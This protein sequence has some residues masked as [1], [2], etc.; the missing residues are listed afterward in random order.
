MI[1]TQ[2]SSMLDPELLSVFCRVAETLNFS[3][4]ATYLGVAQPVVTRKI[5]RLEEILGVPLFLRS[6]RGCKLTPEGELLATKA[7]GILLQLA[8]LK[9]E[10]GHSNIG[11]SGSIA[12]GMTGAAG[13]LLAPHLMP[14]IAT[15]W[16]N[17]RVELYE[18]VTRHLL[19]S[20]VNRELSLALVYDPPPDLGLLTQPLLMDHLYLAGPADATEE[21]KAI[22]KA[23]VK[24]IARLP[25]VLPVRSQIIREL[26]EDA[27]AEESLPLKPRYEANSPIML[28]AMVTQGLGYTVLTMSSLEQDL[29][30]GKLAAIPILDRGMSLTLSLVTNTDYGQ[31]RVVHMM[32]GLISDIVQNLVKSNQWPGSPQLMQVRPFS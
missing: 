23:S 18:A 14:A 6:N 13:T 1:D 3:R 27:F 19:Q 17:L 12:I 26:L 22:S 11:L 32:A 9:E 29:A 25:L 10:I 8:H 4:A 28:K 21:L 30:A 16:P 15:R 31:L 5:R 7:S 20:V 24:D 2:D